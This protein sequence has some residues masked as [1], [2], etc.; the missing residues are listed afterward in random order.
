VLKQDFADEKIAILSDW[1][2][3]A[4]EIAREGESTQEEAERIISALTDEEATAFWELYLASEDILMDA[5]QRQMA[6][7]DV[8]LEYEEIRSVAALVWARTIIDYDPDRGDLAAYLMTAS[9]PHWRRCLR[10]I[11]RTDAS[12]GR[13]RIGRLLRQLRVEKRTRKGREPSLE[14]KVEYVQ[15]RNYSARGKDENQVVEVIREVEQIQPPESLDDGVG[16][17]EGSRTLRE[18]LPSPSQFSIDTKEVA[19]LVAKKTQREEL[20]DALLGKEPQPT[21]FDPKEA[22]EIYLEREARD[23]SPKQIAWE[24]STSPYIVAHVE[25]IYDVDVAIEDVKR[26]A[27]HQGYDEDQSEEGSGSSSTRKLSDDQVREICRRYDEEDT[28]YAELAEDYPA[29]RQAI[30]KV[31]RGET[32][33]DVDRP[34]P[35]S[36]PEQSTLSPEQV[37]EICERYEKEDVSQA[38]LAEEYPVSRSLIADIVRGEAYQDVDRPEREPQQR[39]LSPDQVREICERYDEEDIS[40]NKLAEDYPVGEDSVGAVVRGETYQD[41]DRPEP[42]SRNST[43]PEPNSPEPNSPELTAP[44]RSGMPDLSDDQVVEICLRYREEDITYADLAEEYDVAP[45]TIGGIVRGETYRHVDR[46][47]PETRSLSPDQ[48]R[49]ICRR[50]HQEDVSYTELAEDY[51]A[52]AGTIG[53]IVRNETYQDVDRPG[54]PS[55][56]ERPTLSPEQV[57]EICER[58]EKEDITQADLAEDYAVSEFAIGRVVRGETYPDIDRP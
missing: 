52:E 5:G 1:L 50:Y 56:P 57:V 46:P 36:R 17:E 9:R 34:G 21:S 10:K 24:Y 29:G 30:G 45:V 6:T 35:P 43:S 12:C 15:E 58:Y 8:E 32:Y 27:E 7:S 53:G 14:E 3:D 18:I 54:P 37:V 48:V 44:R 11:S 33:Q 41:V 26:H 42:A 4:G 51:P 13:R 2:A 22:K 49:E 25:E 39:P 55:R 47:E 38:D 19:R 28:T 16:E 20:L 31:V 40:Y 23:A